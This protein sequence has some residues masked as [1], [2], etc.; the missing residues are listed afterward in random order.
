VEEKIRLRASG[1]T[2]W[3]NTASQATASLSK[4]RLSPTCRKPGG[5]Y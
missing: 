1:V 5:R 4:K 2:K 3:A